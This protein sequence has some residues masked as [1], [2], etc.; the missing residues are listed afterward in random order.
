MNSKIGG[1]GWD[2][3]N[4][5][6]IMSRERSRPTRSRDVDP[7]TKRRRPRPTSTP[8]SGRIHPIGS[9]D[10]QSTLS[11]SVDVMPQSFGSTSRP[12]FRLPGPSLDRQENSG[13]S[14]RIV[15]DLLISH[16]HLRPSA[17]G[18][19]GSKVAGKARMCTT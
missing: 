14:F 16:S 13:W 10:W 15:E 8:S 4:D 18:L 6:P 7:K 17:E 19:A 11:R 2:R 1:P 12:T 3:T 9:Q 5:Q